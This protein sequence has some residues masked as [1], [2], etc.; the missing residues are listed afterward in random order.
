MLKKLVKYLLLL[1][2]LTGCPQQYVLEQLKKEPNIK[3][4]LLEN[5][6][7]VNVSTLSGLYINVAGEEVALPPNKVVKINLNK[8]ILT[9]TIGDSLKINGVSFPFSF[10]GREGYVKI[11]SRRYRGIVKIIERNNLLSIINI[12]P[13]EIYLYGV[14][15]KEI[16][17]LKSNRIEAIKAQAVAARTYAIKRLIERSSK[18][19]N[20]YGDVRDQVY[21]G[22]DAE[23]ELGKRAVDE[24]KGE[25]MLYKEDIVEAKYSS[26]C[27][28]ITADALDAWAKDFPYLRGKPDTKGHRKG[29][30]IFCKFSPHNKWE[31]RIPID[32]FISKIESIYPGKTLK[33][34]KVKWNK[35]TKRV[36][37][38]IL[39]TN[40]GTFTMKGYKFRMLFGLKSTFFTIKQAGSEVVIKG[41]G[42][43]HG[44]G[45][46][47]YGAMGMA[48]KGYSYRKILKHYYSH[49][50]IGNLYR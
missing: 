29:G 47:Q 27:G 31:K 22:M 37:E 26:S 5:K 49:I 28:G 9:L 32:V 15:P 46:C 12:L 7:S 13:I 35:K 19:F 10:R 3:V 43:G 34:W 8:G 4:L 14:V 45:M 6:K 2:I 40:K 38:V 25:I 36:K 41:R 24:T 11:N 33:A 50:W 17:Y 44:T 16:G 42:Y 18:I 1:F 48:D 23:Y 20:I 21:G 39:I 30:E